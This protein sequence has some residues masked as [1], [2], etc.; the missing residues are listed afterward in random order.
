MESSFL[1]NDTFQSLCHLV[2]KL[3]CSG[4]WIHVYVE[5]T[6]SCFPLGC[7]NTWLQGSLPWQVVALDVPQEPLKKG[8]GE[9]DK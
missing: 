2:P 6:P 4:F 7:W 8:Y 1:P 5:E 9:S 3:S